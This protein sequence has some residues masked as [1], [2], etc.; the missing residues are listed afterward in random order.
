MLLLEGVDPLQEVFHVVYG[1]PKYGCPVHLA[2]FGD[3]GSEHRETVVEALPAASLRH[4]I[5]RRLPTHLLHFTSSSSST[6]LPDRHRHRLSR[7]G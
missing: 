4:E 7:R 3:N 2:N 5:L 6:S 1:V